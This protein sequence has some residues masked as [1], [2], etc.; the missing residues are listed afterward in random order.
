VD[1]NPIYRNDREYI[2]TLEKSPLREKIRFGR[3]DSVTGQFFDNW[4]PMRHCRPAKDFLFEDWQPVWVGWD[5]G[6]GHY[7]CIVFFTKAILKPRWDGDAPRRV[8]I[9]IK[10]LVLHE[11]TPG[12]Q[13]SALISAIPRIPRKE[14]GQGWTE[15]DEQEDRAQREYGDYRWHIQSVHFS[16]ERFN[17]TVSNRTVADE[18]GEMLQAAGLP[19]PTRSNT[20]RI[21]G[22]QR[23]YDLLD[24]DEFFVVEG[25]C[26]TLAEAI[27]MLVRGDGVTHSIEDVIKP[28][29]LSLNDDVADACLSGG[30]LIDTARGLVPIEEVTTADYVLTRKGFKRVLW[31]GCTGIKRVMQVDTLLITPNHPV[32]ADGRFLIASDTE[33]HSNLLIRWKSYLKARS[34]GAIQAASG[35][36]YGDISAERKMGATR[37]FISRFTAACMEAFRKITTSIMPTATTS[38]TN[39]TILL[40][41]QHVNISGITPRR[42]SY[43]GNALPVG[44]SSSRGEIGAILIGGTVPRSALSSTAVASTV[45]TNSR[46]QKGSPDD[47]VPTLASQHGAV[48]QGL[49]MWQRIVSCA[50]SLSP[51]IATTILGFARATVGAKQMQMHEPRPVYNLSVEEMEEY[52][53]NGILV[54]NCRYGIAGTLLDA[55]DKP[56]HIKQREK[57]ASIKDPMARAVASYT[58]YNKKRA[59]EKRPPKP[60]TVPTWYNRMRPQ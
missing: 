19:I 5:Y 43:G 55:E 21:A 18:V 40:R 27:P 9:A 10:E 47:S 34:I 50:A 36:T 25:Q 45:E 33:C 23:M 59:A 14:P 44:A 7:A 35:F 22:W 41:Y 52:F 46:N 56:E 6:F 26:P 30:T 42:E 24:T 12:E 53:A 31:S 54:H 51:A 58:A 32:F 8:N 3:L 11:R 38:T 29:G 17:R 2:E 37:S 4:E 1:Q 48:K 60:V 16:W 20:D 39:P 57:L 13:T 15:E 28:K 49:T